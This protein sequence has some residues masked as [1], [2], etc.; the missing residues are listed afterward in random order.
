MFRENLGRL[1]IIGAGAGCLVVLFF[2]VAPMMNEPASQLTQDEIV[3]EVL[4]SDRREDDDSGNGGADGDGA[5]PVPSPLVAERNDGQEVA[6]VF[7]A[8]QSENEEAAVLP[9]EGVVEELRARESPAEESLLPQILSEQDVAEARAALEDGVSGP[10]LPVGAD[11]AEEEEG[12]LSGNG[13]TSEPV[14]PG[15]GDEAVAAGGAVPVPEVRIAADVAAA[16]KDIHAGREDESSGSVVPAP[17]AEVGEVKL[18]A[19]VRAVV[20]EPALETEET[21]VDRTAP[22]V[23]T[24]AVRRGEFDT[25]VSLNSRA[26][27]EVSHPSGRVPESAAIEA[28]QAGDADTGLP[29]RTGVI[30]PRTLRGVMGYRLPLVSRQEVPDQIVSGVL[31]PAHTTFVILKEGSWELVDVTPEE[32]QRLVEAE[33]RRDAPVVQ[34]EPLRKGW[35]PLRIF[36]K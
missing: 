5:M 21:G 1:F 27:R 17:D 13:A 35:N 2:V 14:L 8:A 19:M 9:E 36:R 16:R 34:A 26:P 20:R 25:P 28:A 32:V 3:A 12:E 4:G 7:P 22:A 24:Q 10:A 6:V 18:Q 23:E 29:A 31:I 30:V 33:A 11:S 15:S